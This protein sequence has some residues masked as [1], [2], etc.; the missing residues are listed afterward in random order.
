MLS[1]TIDHFVRV[2]ITPRTDREVHVRSLDLGE[3]VAYHLDEGPEYD[4]VMDLAK[5]A[6]ERMGVTAGIDMDIESEAPAGSGLGGSSALVTAVCAGLAML[7]DRAYSADELARLAYAVEREDLE[8]AGGWQDQYASACGGFNLLEFARGGVHVTPVRTDEAAVA[9][10]RSNLLLCYTGH[11]RRHVGL[12][13]EQI[14]LYRTGREDTLL[15]MKQLREM[16]YAMRDVLESGEVDRLGTMLRDAFDAKKRMNPHIAEDT[17]IDEMLARGAA[18]GR[19]RRQDLRRRRRRVPD[20]VLPAAG[21][22][23]GAGRDG[24][25]RRPVRAVRAVARRRPRPPRRPGVGAGVSRRFV[26]VDRDGTINRQTKGSYVLTP[27]AV[28]LLP[29]AAEG[30]R[31][32]RAAG[33]GVIVVTNQAP[34]ARGWITPGQLTAIN[35]RLRTCCAT[36]RHVA[37]DL[38]PPPL[39][40]RG[41]HPTKGIE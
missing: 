5:A 27:D 20:A 11:V 26:L 22:V 32:L 10:L 37:A 41:P 24:G 23:G 16:A 40:S 6:I 25:P 29:G 33:L 4:G 30:L 21:A 13:D 35:A 38:A 9:R 8:I 39:S 17:P 7:E 15:G 36:R 18:R 3:L 1:S 28:V 2:I 31:H 12:I 19:Q 34:V 14:R